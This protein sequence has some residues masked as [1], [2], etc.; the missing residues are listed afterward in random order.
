MGITHD[1]SSEQ[2]ICVVG[3]GH[4][5][6]AVAADLAIRGFAVH[7][8]DRSPARLEVITARR[9]I[10]AEGAISGFGPIRLATTDPAEALA[11]CRAVIITVPATAHSEVAT[12][13]AP[14]LC[15]G[16]TIVLNPG[17]FLGSLV[18][19][20]ALQAA[21]CQADASLCETQT[22]LCRARVVAPGKVRVLSVRNA[23]PIAALRSHRT[24]EVLGRL[25][26]YLPEL[27]PGDSVLRTSLNNVGA[28]LHPALMLLNAGW[29]EDHDDFRLYQRGASP[30]VC[31]VLEAADR[32]R[33]GVAAALGVGAMTAREWQYLG[34][35]VHADDLY[36][37]ILSNPEYESVMSPRRLQHRYLT[38]DIPT[39]LVPIAS[40]GRQFGAP[41][42]T[43]EGLI[44]IGGAM[45]GVDYW[46]QGRTVERLGLAGL[47]LRDLRLLVVD[48]E[49][50]A[51]PAAQAATAAEEEQP[52]HGH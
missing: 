43:I 35:G 5:G 4:S 26:Q 52:P 15:D 41:A 17:R 50:A 16:C 1:V 33:V 9:G 39:N 20:Q 8:H 51:E 48:G 21:G 23:V 36:T 10:E 24:P 25:R 46:A 11:G 32:E 27:V 37:A 45:T 3:A 22:S 19:R 44:Q 2:P 6:L 7:L 42:P 31:H 18:W 29:V 14:A 30:A 34:Y 49:V 13:L 38:E 28:V 40:L 12:R 47:S